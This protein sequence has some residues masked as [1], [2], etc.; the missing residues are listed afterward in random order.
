M[1]NRILI[2]IVLKTLIAIL[3]VIA[4]TLLIEIFAPTDVQ[5]SLSLLIAFIIGFVFVIEVI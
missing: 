4:E 3:C 5:Q 2:S 1:R